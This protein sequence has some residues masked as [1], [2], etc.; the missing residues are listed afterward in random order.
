MAVK[1]SKAN[2]DAANYPTGVD[3]QVSDGHLFVFDTQQRIAIY[4]PGKWIRAEY[5]ADTK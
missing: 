1:V 4:A 2:G 5:T 3:I